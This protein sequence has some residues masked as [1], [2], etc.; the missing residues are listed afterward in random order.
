MKRQTVQLLHPSLTWVSGDLFMA[1][2]PSCRLDHYTDRIT[3]WSEDGAKLQ[4]SEFDATYFCILE[5][6]VWAHKQHALMQE[7]ALFWFHTGWS[8]LANWVNDV[9]KDEVKMTYHQSHWLFIEN[10]SN[11][12][13]VAH[14]KQNTFTCTAHPSSPMLAN[15][16]CTVI[17]CN[18]GSVASDMHH[19]CLDCTHIK[20]Y[21]ADLV[22]EGENLGESIDR[23]A[24]D[25]GNDSEV[26][27]GMHFYSIHILYAL[28]LYKAEWFRKSGG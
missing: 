25:G 18:G 8:N 7:K 21:H 5:N 19:R 26:E 27:D 9:V 15:C 12:L 17:G 4:K 3:Y 11:R 20:Q 13:M 10:F 1:H 6:G 14:G 16:V 24:V 23:L 22:N 2:C 28:S